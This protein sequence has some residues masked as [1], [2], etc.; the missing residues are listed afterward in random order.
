MYIFLSFIVTELLVAGICY[1]ILA[2]QNGEYKPEEL[3]RE[4]DIEDAGSIIFI[5]LSMVFLITHF[6][7]FWA[8]YYDG[9][10]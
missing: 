4:V 1:M 3:I 2:L 8:S 7:L 9:L 5:I 10:V 6:V